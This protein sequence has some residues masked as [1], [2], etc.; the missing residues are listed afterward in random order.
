M[1][2]AS[3]TCRTAKSSLGRW[4]TSVN[5]WVRFD[6]PAVYQGNEVQGVELRFKD[7]R[8][9]EAKADKND[10]FLQRTLDTDAGS[11]FLGEFAIG[12]NFGVQR[13]TKEI[14][15]DEKFGGTIHLALG[16]GYP[17]TGS[18]NKSS[19]H[20]DLICDM[21]RDSEITVDG[22]VFYKDGA[23]KV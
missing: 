2:A 23:F 21:R 11:R 3:T 6:F 15:F 14:L 18:V 20:W 1:P 22:S 13:I 5:G 16:A 7:G 19:V 9:A 12:N 8:V 17:D 10:A 4:R